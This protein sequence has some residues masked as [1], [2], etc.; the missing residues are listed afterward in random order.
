M[1]VATQPILH[2]CR[3]GKL[4]KSSIDG[5]QYLIIYESLEG[6]RATF[7]WCWRV[8]ELDLG[9]VCPYPGIW[10][11]THPCG[12][13]HNVGIIMFSLKTYDIYGKRKREN[14]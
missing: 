9:M 2:E 8:C 4:K 1:F 5:K 10:G 6:S 11:S 14:L 13:I 12:N 7:R 3:R